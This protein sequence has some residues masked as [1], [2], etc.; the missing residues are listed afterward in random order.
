MYLWR[1]LAFDF[2]PFL[3]LEVEGPHIV[4]GLHAVCATENQ[5]ILVVFDHREVG[6]PLRFFIVPFSLVND[7]PGALIHIKGQNINE[8]LGSIRHIPSIYVH[9]VLDHNCAVGINLRN[10]WFGLHCLPL[11][12]HEVIDE[13]GIAGETGRHLSPEDN[14]FLLVDH[15]TVALQFNLLLPAG[16]GQLLPDVLLAILR[17]IHL[18]EVI[19]HTPIDIVP[20]VHEQRTAKHS[21]NVIGATGDIFALDLD[22]AP[23]IVKG[24]LKVGVDD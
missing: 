9:L 5:Q 23:T 19:Q 22:L 15:S 6:P 16:I 17:N 8:I 12:S 21:S 1:V 13:Y 18:V 10:V 7:F 3:L 14:Q 11:P 2:R 24:I 20:S 4:H